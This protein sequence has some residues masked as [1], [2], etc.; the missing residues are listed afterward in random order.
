MKSVYRKY[1]TT[2]VLIWSGCFIF[3]LFVH[4]L[5][6]AP[7]KNI[8]N[9]VER[10]LAE[11]RQTYDSASKTTQGQMKLEL[12]EQIERLRNDLRSFVIDSEDSA[13]LTFDISRIA[14]EKKVSS[15][16]IDTEYDPSGSEIPNCSYIRE[17]RM[18][19]SFTVADFSQFA[20]FLN[21]LERHLPVVFV[22]ELSLSYSDGEDSGHQVNMKLSV[23]VKKRQD[24]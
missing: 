13:G 7:Q 23:F 22:D 21:A 6:I 1:L 24:S 2:T 10:Q 11:E 5:V 19:V 15:F 8:K 20:G 18:D 9:D 14:N 12:S 4:M 16:S 17:S 3:F